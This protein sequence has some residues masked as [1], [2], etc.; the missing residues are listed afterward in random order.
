MG[1]L[2]IPG[3]PCIPNAPDPL[4]CPRRTDMSSSAFRSPAD[5]RATACRND[6]LPTAKAAVAEGASVNENGEAP[7]WLSKV[8]PLA[9]ALH[10]QLYDAALWLLTHGADPNGHRETQRDTE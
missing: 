7:G 6:D 1:S 8:L 9:I 10:K 2:C 3:S 5:R 4:S